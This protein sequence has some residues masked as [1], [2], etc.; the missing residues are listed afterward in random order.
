M[1]T[2]EDLRA[3]FQETGELREVASRA[4]EV[5]IVSGFTLDVDP[6]WSLFYD[7]EQGL[8][9]WPPEMAPWARHWLDLLNLVHFDARWRTWPWDFD[10]PVLVWARTRYQ[11]YRRRDLYAKVTAWQNLEARYRE[12]TNKRR[13]PV[14][15]T[16]VHRPVRPPREAQADESEDQEALRR[17]ISIAREAP[18]VVRVEERPR[19]RFALTCGAGIRTSGGKSGTLGG[20]LHDGASNRLYGVSCAHVA[21]TGDTIA[22]ASSK[23]IGTCNADTALIPLPGSAVCDPINLAVPS[24]F[25]GNGPDVNMLDCALIE[26]A[27]PVSPPAIAGVAHRLSPCQNVVL[28]GAATG[29]TRHKLGSLCLSYSFAEGGQDFCFRDAIE[30]LPQP[31]GPFGGTLGHVMTKLPTQGDSGG[32]V[33]TDD[34]PPHWAGLFFGEDGQRGFAIRASWV[35]DWVQRAFGS[36]LSLCSATSSA[37]SAGGGASALQSQTQTPGV[38]SKVHSPSRIVDHSTWLDID[39]VRV[40]KR[41]LREAAQSTRRLLEEEIKSR[42]AVLRWKGV[43]GGRLTDQEI[44]DKVLRVLSQEGEKKTIYDAILEVM[45]KAERDRRILEGL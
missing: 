19:A 27:V 25:P 22:D 31:W 38:P 23:P 45:E 8:V 2:Y 13:L 44:A 5:G 40:E 10:S 7:L 18:V 37:L 17:L 41:R 15:T 11:G 20:V 1:P 4:S 36:S 6:L 32:W 39:G 35:Y 16:I 34:D 29:T 21:K 33:L 24:S 3:Y 9:D 43:E 14:T 42:V 30:L 26:L 12:L 28:H